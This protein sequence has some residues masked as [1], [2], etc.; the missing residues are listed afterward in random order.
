G[1]CA[2]RPEGLPPR[3]R[4]AASRPRVLTPGELL[5]RLDLRL[6]RL[7]GGQHALP[8]RQ[9]TLRATLDWTVDL[10][11]ED[12]LYQLMHLAVFAGGCTLAAAEAVAGTSIEQL[13]SLI[14]HN[15][16]RQLSTETG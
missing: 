14:D 8:A 10:L 9:Q 1:R 2:D 15:L 5:E 7:T 6:P 3:T 11:D 13:S 16:V 12:E 4:P